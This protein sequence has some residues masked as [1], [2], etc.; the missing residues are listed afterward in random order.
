MDMTTATT[1]TRHAV[2][3]GAAATL[4]IASL[5][6]SGAAQARD[7]VSWSV[8][9]GT[10]GAVITVGNARPIYQAPVYVQ[11]A[12]VYVQPAPVYVQPAP[13]YY[14]QPQTYYAPAPVYYAP[15]PVYY[16]RPYRGHGNYYH[17][18]R[19]YSGQ[20]YEAVRYFREGADRDHRDR[21]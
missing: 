16:E 2:L 4:A 19:G 11:P 17:G 6:F 12:P 14:R 20:R 15:Q 10:P 21:R 5:G 8:G 9:I 7:N 13:V 1:A 18:N 3:A